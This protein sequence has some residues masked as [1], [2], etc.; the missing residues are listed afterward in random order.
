[1]MVSQ[2]L[3][4]AVKLSPL[5]A[6][7]IAHLAG[8]HPSTLSKLLCGIEI[9]REND[10]RVISIGKIVGLSSKDCFVSK[11]KRQPGDEP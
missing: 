3:K 5:R 9:P 4:I 11:E 1:M 6:Y 7:Q 2:D 10:K 8:I